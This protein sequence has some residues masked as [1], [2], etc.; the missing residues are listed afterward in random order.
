MN[1]LMSAE[2]MTSKEIAEMTGKS[3][4][5]LLKEIRKMEDTWVLLG[6]VRFDLTSYTD[7]SNRQS[8]MYNLT[9][10]ESLYI[11][12]KFNDTARAKVI[13]RWQE[14]ELKEQ[15]QP[16]LPTNFVEALKSLIVSEEEKNKAQACLDEAN[17]V[18]ASNRG[19]VEFAESVTGSKNSISVGEYAK[20]L[21]DGGFEIGQNRLFQLLRDQGFL[22]QNNEPYQNYVKQ[23]L[24]EVTTHLIDT[25]N[26]TLT[27]RTTKITGKGQIYLTKRI[28]YRQS[29]DSNQISLMQ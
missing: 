10:T 4:A 8:K 5:N 20:S 22:M 26:G 24:F 27:K 6:Q 9:K 13:L 18:I 15:E 7:K 12:T 3:H 14:L 25:K 29:P 11:A 2:R 1:N 23:G 17:S 16:K 19:K 21:C 28:K